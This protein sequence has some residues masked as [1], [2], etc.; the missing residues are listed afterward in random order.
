MSTKLGEYF[1]QASPDSLHVTEWHFQP[2]TSKLLLATVPDR[3]Y[4]HQFNDADEAVPYVADLNTGQPATP[5]L[6]GSL[7]RALQH[8]LAQHWPPQA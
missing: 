3:N 2:T 1:W 6:P 4:N 8:Q 7:T 5:V